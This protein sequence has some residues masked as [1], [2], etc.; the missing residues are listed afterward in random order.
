MPIIR[1]PPNPNLNS[2]ESN[3]VAGKRPDTADDFVQCDACD[4]WW[5][6]S[7]A[8]VTDSIAERAWTCA[9]CS[10]VPSVTSR[11]TVSGRASLLRDTMNR[12][13]EKQ[14]LEKQRMELELQRKFLHEQQELWNATLADDNR[15]QRS[16]VSWRDALKRVNEWLGPEEGT[17]GNLGGPPAASQIQQN[18]T[19]PTASTPLLGNASDPLKLLEEKLDICKTSRRRRQLPPVNHVSSPPTNSINPQYIPLANRKGTQQ[20]ECPGHA[21]SD[22]HVLAP[23]QQQVVSVNHGPTPQQLSA[24]QSLGRD[25]PCFSGNPPEWPI[26]IS[27]YENTTAACGYT[28]GE[29]ML[30]LQRCLKGQA[31]ETVRS[32]LVLPQAVPH[33]IETLRM[34]YGRPELLINAMLRDVRAMP[35]LRSEKLEGLIEYGLA[36]QGLCDHI[37]AANEQAH[38]TNPTLLQELVGKLPEN[39]KLMWA[40]FKRNV[41]NADLS[42]FCE[43]MAGIVRDAS[44]V[45]VSEPEERKVMNKERRAKAYV[46]SHTPVGDATSLPSKEVKSFRCLFC[47]RPG[48]RMRE[49][50]AF[51]NLSVEDRWRKVRSLG[52]CQ[53]CLFGHG[54]RSCR[55]SSRCGIEGCQ[56]RHHSLLHNPKRVQYESKLDSAENHAHDYLGSCVLFRIFPV[57]IYGESGK[58]DVYAF[59][60]EGS[61]LTLVERDLAAQIGLKGSPQPLCLYWTGN[62]SRT[63]ET[64]QKVSFDIAGVGK[65]RRYKVEGAR[66]V[67][68]LNLPSQSFKAE[69]AVQRFEHLQNLPV[70]GYENAVPKLFIGVDN[71]HLAVPLKTKEGEAGPVAVKTRLGWCVYGK[72]RD[73]TCNAYS[74]HICECT[75]YEQLHETMKQFFALEQA[76]I[77]PAV[78]V[79]EEEERAQRILES[80]TRRI[81]DRFETG[82]LWKQ[83]DITLPDSYGM[84]VRRLECL[85]RRMVRN[86]E[87]KENL[88]R[89]I[90]EYEAK[91]YAHKATEAE[92]ENA[93]PPVFVAPQSIETTRGLPEDVATFGSTCSP[94]SAQYVKNLNARNHSQIYPRAAQGIIDCHYVDDYL[95][96][97]GSSAEAQQVAKEVRLVHSKGGFTLRGWRSNSRRVLKELGE[98]D[99]VT[100]KSL[101]LGSDDRTERVLGMLWTPHTD[102]LSF[103]TQMSTEVQTLLLR[104]NRPTKRQTL[105]CVMTLFDPLGLLSPFVVHGK[106]LIQNLWRTGAEWDKEVD[107]NSFDLWQK[108]IKMIGFIGTVRI[109]RCYF[110]RATAETYNAAQ[111]HV[112]VDASEKVYACAVY[113]RTMNNSAKG[114]CALLAGKARVAPVKPMSVLGLELKGC[115]IGAR[116]AKHVQEHHRIPIDRRFYWTDS[117]TALSWIR[118]DPRNYRP[119]VAHRIGEILEVSSVA[120]WRWVP[121]KLNPADEATKWGKGPYFSDESKWFAGPTFL[122]LPEEEWPHQVEATVATTEEVRMTVLLHTTKKFT[123]FCEPFSHWESLLGVIRCVLR[124]INNIRRGRTRF[125]EQLEQNELR[126]ARD[127][128]FN[129]VQYEIYTEEIMV[130]AKIDTLPSTTQE[131]SIRTVAC[132]NLC[133]L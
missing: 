29:N 102:E 3:C 64:S 97:F 122:Q 90:A 66:T 22:Q 118:G 73:N 19:K 62:T 130:L 89:Q 124:F 105:R 80:T 94:A 11:S 60:D 6:Y 17:V 129:Q 26:F 72:Q 39:Q 133:R 43:Y 132:T 69:T 28:N 91:G 106:I 56:Y 123:V 1:T 46:N 131:R 25:L 77:G 95:D 70:H 76:S 101:A 50:A 79:S 40:G 54:R 107:D 61:S 96:T 18:S 31:M 128:V 27:N 49:C 100:C 16:R 125:A 7:C 68:K 112:F 84:A 67:A 74:F 47:D 57:T 12:L 10:A 117:T 21:V 88:H 65:S 30:R 48:H 14:E 110:T 38:L 116:L 121:S 5:H 109:P 24:R 41:P 113:I 2:E 55:S 127:A 86:P 103:S 71:L 33:I 42:A 44:T 36:V 85:E 13:K 115:V 9:N 23:N 15:S 114:Q 52:L 59:L 93:D 126:A 37:I 8:G 87:L 20:Q 58:A 98:S 120:E 92:M 81:G 99:I 35:I 4:A 82:L 45:V 63:E 53:N 51:Q 78:V 75:T 119:Y 111:M 32:R 104:K 108:W 83:D 34:R